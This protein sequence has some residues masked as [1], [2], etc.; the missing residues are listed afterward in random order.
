M[1]ED[2]FFF[3]FFLSFFLSSERKGI[4]SNLTSKVHNA[5]FLLQV[6]PRLERKEQ[7]CYYRN[8]VL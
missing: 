8:Q 7:L 1:S 4:F 6:S 5:R 2:S 3:L